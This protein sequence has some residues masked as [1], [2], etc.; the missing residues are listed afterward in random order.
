MSKDPS[1][2]WIGRW[3]RPL[4]GT[5]LVR[6]SRRSWWLPILVAV[7]LALAGIW[8][9]ST[10]E[11]AMRREIRDG[12]ETLLRINV[13][14][15]ENWRTGHERVARVMAQSDEIL[16]VV[17]NPSAESF[18]HAVERVVAAKGY[19]GY[20]LLDGSGRLLAARRAELIGQR[21]PSL[22]PFLA[23]DADVF[24][25]TPI[26][27]EGELVIGL[28]ARLPGDRGWLA[29][30]IDPEEFTSRLGTGRLGRT[31]E[32]YAFN[33]DGTMVSL[34]RF[35]ADLAALGL[36]REGQRSILNIE[37]RNPGGDMTRGF[38]P[39]TPLKAR[40]LTRMAAGAVAMMDDPRI[41][42][43]I[44]GY[45]DYRGVPVVG[46]WTWL[47]EYGIG[48]AS[49]MDVE[50]AYASLSILRRVVWVLIVLLSVLALGA[51]AYNFALQKLRAR[52]SEAQQ[53]G[54][55]SLGEKIGQG[56]MGEVYRAEHAMLKRPTAIKLLPSGLA[57]TE[58]K[59]RFEREV[60]MTSRLSHHNTVAIYD[61]GTTPDG[62]FYY[63]ME[64]V[65]GVTL[66]QMVEQTGPVPA[67]R[68]LY[69]LEQMCG[70]LAEAHAHG[71]I[72]RD[73]KPANVMVMNKPGL[74]DH[75]K[76]LDFGLVKALGEKS[77]VD[78]SVSGM[79]LGTPRYLSPESFRSSDGVDA[80][81]D[82]Y[83]LGAIAYFMVTGQH[84]FEGD[85]VVEI[86]NQHMNVEPVRPSERLGEPVPTE[87]EEAILW[88]LRKDPD[89]RP[90]SVVALL[91]R[92]ETIT[93]AGHW[94]RA[95]AERWWQGYRRRETEA[96]GSMPG[97]G[98]S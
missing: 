1:L 59:I 8:T 87:I 58:R 51:A 61:Y 75:V 71:L 52:V 30:G 84:V 54:Q 19:V 57:D 20:A 96:T 48:V 73:L 50:E 86:V 36:L 6:S 43:D 21:V 4:G 12:M 83:A 18:A 89:E 93:D 60:Q 7:L 78:V 80:R 68:A 41:E 13:V 26:E 79:V 90:I 24:M 33:A 72:H 22:Q 92:L 35:D 77:D 63:A 82:I 66:H 49:E 74:T 31:G 25:T 28:L 9:R 65:D 11:R 5:D 34:S 17:E 40:P 2:S 67:A 37:V 70:S 44:D 76:V 81:A 62:H 10:M 39:S 91:D 64:Y 42:S 14:A 3:T 88:C 46:A 27:L 15:L 29:F 56:G 32:T 38:V 23:T 98:G 45:A 69:L 97:L 16:D 85:T 95:D 47:S 53:L 55:Y 94:T